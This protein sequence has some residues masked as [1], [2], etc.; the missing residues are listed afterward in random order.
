MQAG[1]NLIA[2]GYVHPDLPGVKIENTSKEG[3]EDTWAIRAIGECYSRNGEW[4]YEPSPSSREDDFIA[5]TRYKFTE[6]PVVLKEIID[7]GC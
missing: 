3:K 2:V 7:K 6:L 1:S 5:A 4:L